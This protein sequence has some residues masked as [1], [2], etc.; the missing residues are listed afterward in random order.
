[1]SRVKINVCR[2]EELLQLP[3]VGT[4]IASQIFDLRQK[5]GVLDYEDLSS[6]SYLRLSEAFM[7]VVEFTS[8]E[9][10]PQGAIRPAPTHKG[11]PHVRD[12]VRRVDE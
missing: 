4:K 9:E 1:M 8:F 12:Q 10:D 3:G 5:K 7:T 11:E 2:F 6:L